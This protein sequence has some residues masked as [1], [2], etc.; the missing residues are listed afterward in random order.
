VKGARHKFI[1]KQQAI[2][3]TNP[4]RLKMNGIRKKKNF[5]GT[6]KRVEKQISI[7]SFYIFFLLL[8]KGNIS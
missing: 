1:I 8:F 4:Y 3:K 7:S 5:R 6:G 2:D